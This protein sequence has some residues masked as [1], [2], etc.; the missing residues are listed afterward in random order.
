[1]NSITILPSKVKIRKCPSY[2]SGFFISLDF[3]SVSMYMY[4]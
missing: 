4:I 1:M 3:Q 2:L